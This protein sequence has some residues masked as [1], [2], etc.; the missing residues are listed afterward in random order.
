MQMCWTLESAHERS[1]RLCVLRSAWLAW[2]EWLVGI[3]KTATGKACS[4]C[5]TL[6]RLELDCAKILGH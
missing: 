5:K 6:G 4:E 1:D 3:A 2:A